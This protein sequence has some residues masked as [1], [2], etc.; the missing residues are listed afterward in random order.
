MEKS[1]PQKPPL[2]HQNINHMF[3][4]SAF[5]F[6]FVFIWTLCLG[7]V[8][9]QPSVVG[10][11]FAVDYVDS[12]RFL[13]LYNCSTTTKESMM[14]LGQISPSGRQLSAFF[15]FVHAIGIWLTS[16][17]P[18]IGRL[19]A[20]LCTCGIM[21]LV[22]KIVHNFTRSKGIYVIVPMLAGS[23]Y[24][25]SHMT[26]LWSSLVRVDNLAIFVFD[27]IYLYTSPFSESQEPPKTIKIPPVF[28]PWHCSPN[29]RCGQHPCLFCYTPFF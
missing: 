9:T 16:P 17:T 20:L 5:V 1:I 27:G 13:K 25:S 18:L 22:A 3:S 15:H 4:L 21:T 14:T 23:F 24:A 6:V 8:A 7:N 29:K 11:P 12:P 28:V 26:M 19:I 2:H 10:Y